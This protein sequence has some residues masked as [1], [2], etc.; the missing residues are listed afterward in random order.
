M[1]DPTSRALT[2]LGLLESRTSWSGPE[3]AERLGVT[4]RT[5]R[6]DI[7]RLRAVGYTVE[8][9]AG[10]EGGYALGRRQ[11]LPPLLLDED[12]AAAVAVALTGAALGSEGVHAPAALRALAKLDDVMPGPARARMRELR[13]AVTLSPTAPRVP[14]TILMPCADAVQ[15]R[16]RLAFT[17][18]DR[19]G[20]RTSRTVEPHRL[21]AR[22]QVWR[23]LAYDPDRADWRTFRLD[24]M[25]EPAL[26]TWRFTPREDAEAAMARMDAPAP[27]SAWEH[28]VLVHIHA[29]L[30][31]VTGVL[32]HGA[33]RLR[34]TAAEVTE[35]STGVDEPR[36]AALWLARLPYPFTVLGNEAVRA[37]VDELGR[38]LTAAARP[39]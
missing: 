7:E 24:R 1:T 30:S 12:E 5:V 37:A 3:L 22:G 32:P 26:S 2:L 35:L 38:R 17:Y 33:G 20:A 23:L 9:E 15:R 19:R 10:A 29:P 25:T 16:T 36:D 8:A 27:A 39:R 18:T 21:V 28:P 6:R 31:H 13:A 4:T 34:A 14:A 11:V